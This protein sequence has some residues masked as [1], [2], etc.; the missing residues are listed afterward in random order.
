[1]GAQLG[2]VSVNGVHTPVPRF[3]SAESET[4]KVTRTPT[5]DV[6]LEGLWCYNLTTKLAGA[7]GRTR[8]RQAYLVSVKERRYKI[9]VKVRLGQTVTLSFL[10][11][12]G[13]ITLTP[14]TNV[15]QDLTEAFGADPQDEWIGLVPPTDVD[16]AARK[17]VSQTGLK[18][19]YKYK[20]T[21]T[22]VGKMPQVVPIAV[23]YA[24]R[25][26]FKQHFLLDVRILT[27]KPK[28]ITTV[29]SAVH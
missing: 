24:E 18:I 15:T 22:A 27:D 1:M 17:P 11:Y 29:I 20:M 9:G 2:G 10:G 23:T 8:A 25:V 6:T 12:Q 16:A 3:A 5:G 13:W 14:N 28:K 21:V 19:C 26:S 4:K 7:S